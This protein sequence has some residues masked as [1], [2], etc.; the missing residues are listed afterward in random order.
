[1][2]ARIPELKI[3]A[4]EK[5]NIAGFQIRGNRGSQVAASKLT[6]KMNQIA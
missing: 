3:S 5:S 6:V 1:M 4:V 2:I